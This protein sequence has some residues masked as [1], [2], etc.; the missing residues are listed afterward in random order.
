MTDEKLNI[1]PLQNS[2]FR[3]EEAL[4]IY[5]ND[6]SDT[7]IRDGLIQ[8][9]ESTYEV[10]HKMLKR[11][12]EWAS[13]TPERYDNVDFQTL[14]RNGNEQGLLRGEWVD[15]KMYRDMRNKMS[16]AYDEQLALTVVGGIPAFLAEARYLYEQLKIRLS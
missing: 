13:P 6:P 16:H 7:L 10:S 5:Q 12:L 8:R 14:I 3:L 1:T 2:I 4:E 9:F 11:Y 15:W